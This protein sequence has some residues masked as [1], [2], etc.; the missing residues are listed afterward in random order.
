MFNEQNAVENYVRD[1]LCGPQPA[2]G[3]RIGEPRAAY[4]AEVATPQPQSLGWSFL[5]GAQLPRATTDVLVES[6]LRDALIRLNPEIAARPDRADEVL[7]R[8]RAILLSVN[9]DGLVRA[10]EEFAAWL[11]G[12]RSM[13]FGPRGEHTGVRLVDFDAVVNNRCLVATQLVFTAGAQTRRF[14]LVLF[15]NGIPLVVGEAKTPTRPAVSWLDGAIQVHDDYEVNVPAFFAPNVLSF[16]TEGKTYRFGA[17]RMSLDLWAPWREE[18]PLLSRQ[19]RGQG[20]RTGLPEVETAVRGMLRLDVILDILRHFTVFATDKG[21]RKIKIICRFQQY[22]AANQIVERVVKG[23]IKKGLIWHFQGSG[24]SLLIVFAAQ[25]LRLHPD[26]RNPTVLVVVDRV[27]L[28]TQITGAF[29]PS[30]STKPAPRRR[31][32]SSSAS[33]TT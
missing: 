6:H 2:A 20:V 24:K 10:N 29:N 28:D 19:E 13:P 1:L 26:L 32:R 14:D 27:D 25:K 18:P 11:R 5:P 21:R 30:F 7:Y 8:L 9:A 16:A 4:R 12:E 17:I 15:V 33:S 3:V 31:P 23:R 22:H